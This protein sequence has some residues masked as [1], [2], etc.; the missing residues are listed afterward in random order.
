MLPEVLDGMT[1]FVAIRRDGKMYG[2][3]HHAV[4][5]IATDSRAVT[6]GHLIKNARGESAPS[7][8]NML[9]PSTLI[10]SIHPLRNEIKVFREQKMQ[11]K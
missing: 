11:Y 7:Y 3:C 10:H 1:N 6:P 5:S 2:W 9:F 4:G 8:S